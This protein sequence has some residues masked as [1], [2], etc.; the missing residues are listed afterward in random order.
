M[1]K[2]LLTLL[3]MTL[4]PMAMSAET[5]KVKN[6]DGVYVYYGVYKDG[7]YYKAS[8][9]KSPNGYSGHLAIPS[10]FK[11]PNDESTYVEV[12]G[13]NEDALAGCT[14]LTSLSIN[15]YFDCFS[16][17]LKD[18]DNLT[19][20]TISGKSGYSSPSGSVAILRGSTLIAGCKNTVI[21]DYVEKIGKEAFSGCTG[22]TTITIPSSVK[23]IDDRAFYGTGLTEITIPSSVENF[24]GGIFENCPNLT[25][26]T[27]ECEDISWNV[28]KLKAGVFQ[29]SGLKEIQFGKSVRK[30]GDQTFKDCTNLTSVT[31]PSTVKEIGQFAFDRCT[32]LASVT[33]G[34]DDITINYGAFARCTSLTDVIF[35]EGNKVT[36][37]VDGSN[38][39]S[40]Y[41]Y[42]ATTG[43][44][45]SFTA[46]SIFD[47][48]TN[49]Q[50]LTVR[51]TI[52]LNSSSNPFYSD[53][54][55]GAP[56][57]NIYISDVNAW[58]NSDIGFGGTGT[59]RYRLFLNGE[60]LEHLKI[61][62]GVTA[63]ND[64]AFGGCASLKSVTIPNSVKTIGKSAF[65]NCDS[66]LLV[67]SEIENPFTFDLGYGYGIIC[68]HSAED[69]GNSLVG[70]NSYYIYKKDLLTLYVPQFSVE[71]YK[72]TN[73]WNQF[74]RIA[75]YDP[76]SPF[77][78]LDELYPVPNYHK[79]KGLLG[80]ADGDRDVDADDI[81]VIRDYILTGK[82]D[83][84]YKKNADMNNDGK[85]NALDIVLLVNQMTK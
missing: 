12:R 77:I 60:E 45:E 15:S 83:G 67:M 33:I 43:E 26:A 53:F 50:S 82:T 7:N 46:R 76:D 2:N 56:V 21:P 61:P 66:L 85:V 9:A 55:R 65:A 39:G 78:D 80:D 49:L 31:I 48:C 17:L 73:D 4:L 8:V 25:T 54:F 74:P 59:R 14:G 71:K 13:I 40:T 79:K 27:I 38:Y 19:Q 1:K 72:E 70:V 28:G 84:F 63:I 51:G 69:Y 23:R 10:F 42:N 35:E 36:P 52:N 6:D 16:D 18:C 22:L 44:Y 68:Y 24:G 64:A 32:S 34:G 5:W 30:I 47:G 20:I 62:E 11:D 37:V 41:D 75:S 81:A 29:G 58:L 57:P 3:L